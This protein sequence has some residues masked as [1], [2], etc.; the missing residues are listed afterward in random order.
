VTVLARGLSMVVHVL[1]PSHGVAGAPTCRYHPSCSQYAGLA[2]RKHGPLKGSL[3]AAWRI[4]R[5]NP[6][7]AGGVDYP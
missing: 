4:L 1:A 2:L 6:W 5:C 3:K 7:S